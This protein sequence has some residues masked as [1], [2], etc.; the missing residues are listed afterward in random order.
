MTF[1]FLEIDLIDYQGQLKEMVCKDI[2]KYIHKD[3]QLAI[4]LDR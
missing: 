3:D 1:Y 4:L 2:D